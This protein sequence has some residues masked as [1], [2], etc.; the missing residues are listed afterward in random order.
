V[1]HPGTLAAE[2]RERLR[3]G[4]PVFGTFLKLSATDIVEVTRQV[5]FDFAVVDLE[6]SQLDDGDARMLVRHAHAIGFP[7]LVRLPS[8]EP[9]TM[10]RMLEAGAVGLQLP[11]V[12]SAAET[13]EFL[14]S[15]RYPPDGRRSISLSHP[16]A[17]YGADGLLSYLERWADGPLL[18]G[19]IET[20]TSV[21]PL[22]DVLSGLDVAFI[23]ALDLSLEL[24]TPGDTMTEAFRAR[25]ADVARAAARTGVDLGGWARDVVAAGDL[26]SAGARYVLVGSDIALYQ[27]GCKAVQD[28]LRSVT[29]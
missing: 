8:I 29:P 17:A 26:V 1:T 7:T 3:S 24:G 14:L 16:A 25:L 9:G 21:D 20:A 22:E 12:Q 2:F 11:H 28:V 23:G 13:R 19:Q 6:H 4:R 27:E 10:N 5:G 15:T 18:V